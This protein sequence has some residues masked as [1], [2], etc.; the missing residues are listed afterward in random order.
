MAIAGPLLF[1]LF[2]NGLSKMKQEVDNYCYSDD[3]KVIARNQNDMNK[4]TETIQKRLETNKMELN[5][6]KYHILNL[7]RSIMAKIGEKDLESFESQLDLGLI[8]SKN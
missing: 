1:L 6:K 4:K 3:F 8:I 5:T 2:I 7:K